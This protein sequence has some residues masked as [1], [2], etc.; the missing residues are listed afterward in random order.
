MG[1]YFRQLRSPQRP[2]RTRAVHGPPS[3][4]FAPTKF[5]K[6]FTSSRTGMGRVKTAKQAAV[7][8]KSKAVFPEKEESKK[9]E[10]KAKQSKSGEKSSSNGAQASDG[11]KAEILALGGDEEDYELVKDVDSDI[12]PQAGPSS[13][14]ADVRTKFCLTA[15]RIQKNLGVFR[16]RSRKT[17][18]S[19]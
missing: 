12:E 8:H 5:L 6:D 19:S 2:G 3:I 10:S 15:T 7:A 11:L 17:F 9:A 18:P 13:T 4:E 16:N 14:K 1:F